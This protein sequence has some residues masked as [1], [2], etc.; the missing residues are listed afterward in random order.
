MTFFSLVDAPRYPDATVFIASKLN[1]S[2]ALFVFFV[3]AAGF[4]Y[5]G[6]QGGFV[7]SQVN[8]PSFL[9]YWIAGVGAF[10]FAIALSMTPAVFR[11]TNW[12][13]QCS[14]GHIVIKFRSL[15][16]YHFDPA[17]IQIV[18]IG[19]L[20]IEW[21]RKTR[22][23]LKYRHRSGA[24]STTRHEAS[25]H[26]DVKLKGS[27]EDLVNRLRVEARRQA[28]KRGAVSTKHHHYPVR[29]VDDNIVRLDFRGISPGI[30]IALETLKQSVAVIEPSARTNDLTAID[31]L[32]RHEVEDRIRQL[33][34]SG[35]KIPA[36]K[37]AARQLNVSLRDAK[38][39]VEGLMAR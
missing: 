36:T 22:E 15:Y 24:K 25:T 38:R 39:L 5:L 33:A 20:E 27:A 12:L 9:C 28:P 13:L 18:D 16:N 21:A 3:V 30:D 4:G 8:L 34:L 14:P 26:L 10:V 1:Q 11:P 6:L 31:G 35:Q 32:N 23:T 19:T 7:T 17:D 29:V 37:I 2:L